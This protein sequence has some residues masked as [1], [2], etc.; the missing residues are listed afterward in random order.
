M[1]APIK[2]AWILGT[3][4]VSALL[5]GTSAAWAQTDPAQVAKGQRIYEERKCAACH[6]I[7]GKGGKAGPELSDVGAKREIQWLNSFMKDPKAI[8]PKAKMLPFKGTEFELEAL[9]AYL[10]SLK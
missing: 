10:A 4:V 7:K 8:V 2:V 9:V 1:R 5:I 6:V 3:A